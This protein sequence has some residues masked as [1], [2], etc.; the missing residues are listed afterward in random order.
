MGQATD[1]EFRVLVVAAEE[2]VGLPLEREIE[3]RSRGRSPSVRVVAP[4][5]AKTGFQH[6][7]GAVDEGREAAQERLEEVIEE[8]ES[9]DLDVEV[10]G[11]VG[12]ADPM[13]AIEDALFDFP[14][15]EIIVVTHAHE[16][17][18][19]WME[20]DLFEKARKRFEP[21]ISHF[22]VGGGEVSPADQSGPGKDASSQDEVDPDSRNLPKLSKRDVAGIVFAVLGSLVLWIIAT[23]NPD[24]TRQ[25]FDWDALHL[26]IAGAVTLVNLSHVVGL[27]LFEAVGYR[28][29]GQRAFANFS[30]YGT[31][32]GIV[33]S[34]LLLFN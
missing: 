4:A 17:E 23:S 12:D 27:M 28:G 26:I 20:D 6:A 31:A 24:T 3:A 15:D 19:R 10:E 13:L 34:L 1:S 21:P 33:A 25:D 22:V 2:H 7:A 29:L 14:A 30:L 5:L 11:R 8:V 9:S 32:A 16:G 18:A